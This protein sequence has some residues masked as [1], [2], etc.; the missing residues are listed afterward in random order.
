MCDGR[1]IGRVVGLL[2]GLSLCLPVEAG[3]LIPGD[4]VSSELRDLSYRP[5]ASDASG[6]YILIRSAFDSP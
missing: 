2:L 3:T 5:S 1:A 6:R 4:R